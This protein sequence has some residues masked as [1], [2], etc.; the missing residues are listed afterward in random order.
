MS[1]FLS[2]LVPFTRTAS[3]PTFPLS[4]HSCVWKRCHPL[5]RRWGPPLATSARDGA[6][7][8]PSFSTLP[9]GTI[10]RRRYPVQHH[11]ER[12]VPLSDLAFVRQQQ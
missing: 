5:D 11:L 2:P 8:F 3:S 1:P 10:V 4:A 7:P 12:V 6:R 9:S